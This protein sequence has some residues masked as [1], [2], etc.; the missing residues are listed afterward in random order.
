MTIH[1]CILAL[2]REIRRRRKAQGLTLERLGEVAG[3]TANYLSNIEAGQRDPSLSSMIRLARAFDAPIG[4][5][6]GMPEMSAD[7][8]EAARLLSGLSAE[9]RDPSVTVKNLSQSLV[10]AAQLRRAR[11]VSIAFLRNT[12]GVHV[13]PWA[14]LTSTPR[15]S[16]PRRP[17]PSRAAAP[18]GNRPP[19]SA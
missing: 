18:C 3:L 11:R 8:I 17:L 16:S 15:R 9:V 6:L 12:F 7:S 1:E 14:G 2:G 10:E 19:R 4:E 13:V 5:L